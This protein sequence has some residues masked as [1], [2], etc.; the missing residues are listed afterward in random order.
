M[1]DGPQ[2]ANPKAEIIDQSTRSNIA[3]QGLAENAG[4]MDYHE[5]YNQLK[6]EALEKILKTVPKHVARMIESGAW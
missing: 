4:F 6:K 3:T 2:I 5:T 1:F